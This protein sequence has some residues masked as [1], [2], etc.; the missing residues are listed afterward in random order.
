MRAST[1]PE[2][3]DARRNAT[4]LSRLHVRP[5]RTLPATAEG[6]ASA[7]AAASPWCGRV[8]RSPPIPGRQ[9]VSQVRSGGD[10]ALSLGVQRVPPHLSSAVGKGL[11][12]CRS[13]DGGASPA[14]AGGALW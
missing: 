10:L 4:L 6:C 2:A 12:S 13:A 8:I 14:T 3:T 5:L 7:T 1:I 11:S 9:C